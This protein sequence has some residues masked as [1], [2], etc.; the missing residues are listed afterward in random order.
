M[1]AT[2]PL[3][4]TAP[5]TPTEVT[6][7]VT[8]VST[9]RVTWQWTSSDP[10]P[11]CFNTTSLIY[12]PEGGDESFLQ[13]SDSAATEATL[14]DL[15]CGT[16]YTITVHTSSGSTDIKST[17]RIVSVPERGNYNISVVFFIWHCNVCLFVLVTGSSQHFT[18]F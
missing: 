7:L 1:I 4:S 2:M 6:A 11:D 16:S 5:P 10:A 3:K 17:P 14:T 18:L 12:C 8:N 9:V 15:Q 13:L